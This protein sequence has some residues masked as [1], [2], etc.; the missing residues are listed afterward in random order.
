MQQ[1]F[2]KIARIFKLRKQPLLDMGLVLLYNEIR[3]HLIP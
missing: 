2:L 3:N 1:D